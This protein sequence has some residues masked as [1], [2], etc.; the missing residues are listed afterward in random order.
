MRNETWQIAVSTMAIRG[1]TLMNSAQLLDQL[2][3]IAHSEFFVRV[4][5]RR[6][7]DLLKRARVNRQL[8][9][10]EAILVDFIP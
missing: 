1:W 5:D 4:S 10:K 8:Q 2:G 9:V 7:V 3:E 6:V